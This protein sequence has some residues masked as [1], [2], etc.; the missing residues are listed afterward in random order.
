ME[1]GELRLQKDSEI[2]LLKGDAFIG[3]STPKWCTSDEGGAPLFGSQFSCHMR[4]LAVGK[5]GRRRGVKSRP[6]L[7]TRCS[8]KSLVLEADWPFC[9]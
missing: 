6:A 4:Y 9:K 1:G 2:H 3:H 8:Y 7:R 5:G